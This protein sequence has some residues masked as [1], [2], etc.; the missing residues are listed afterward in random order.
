MEMETLKAGRSL[1]KMEEQRKGSR[2]NQMTSTSKFQ[3]NDYKITS[4]LTGEIKGWPHRN[5][6]RNSLEIGHV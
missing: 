4:I 2:G 1:K 3:Q 5:R 6:T